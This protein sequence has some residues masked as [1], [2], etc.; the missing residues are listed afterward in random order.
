MQ[1]FQ[2]FVAVALVLAII[3]FVYTSRKSK[4]QPRRRPYSPTKRTTAPKLAQVDSQKLLSITMELR[5]KNAQWNEILVAMNPAG[6][7]RVLNLLSEIRGPHM[8]VPHTALCVIEAGC[9]AVNPGAPAVEA[10]EA[11]LNGMNK[12]V[13]YGN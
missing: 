10:L 2:I 7:S 12:V 5:A 4:Q 11:A 6:D 9:R 1:N 8:F 13:R 3:A